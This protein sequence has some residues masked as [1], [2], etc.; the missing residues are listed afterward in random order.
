LAVPGYGAA[1]IIGSNGVVENITDKLQ[2]QTIELEDIKIHLV[3]NGVSSGDGALHADSLPVILFLHGFPEFHGA[4]SQVL[5]LLI[6][7]HLVIAPDQR[8]YNLS[9]APQELSNYQT[10]LL[11]GDMIAV[12]ESLLPG[13][14]YHLVGHDWG[15][16]IAY[17]MA[18]KQRQRIVTLTIIN[19]VHPIPFQRALSSDE[20]QA[21]ASQY[22]HILR[23][24]DAATHMSDNGFARTFSMFE[25]FS[26]TPWLDERH[27]QDYLN[28]WSQPGRMNAMLNWYRA[29]P[30]IVPI[31][32][33]PV[34]HAPLLD[35]DPAKFTIEMPHQVIWGLQDTAL[36]PV[37]RRGLEEFSK[38]L[39]IVELEDAGHWINH[40]H[41][42]FI[43][44]EIRKFVSSPST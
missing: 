19:G 18:M 35:V 36:L 26:S 30:M 43:A 32:T 17:A 4:W 31:G 15:A 5:P 38:Q 2:S 9:S 13:H 44:E 28:A 29:S 16:S 6:K 41:P 3:H 27:R 12:M 14:D 7:D 33:T 23:A 39:K 37:A 40:T 10:A 21:E 11:V 22:F 42:E 24:P 34:P 1:E 20:K 25:K 8:G